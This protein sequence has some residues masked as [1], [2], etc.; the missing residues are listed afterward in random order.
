MQRRRKPVRPARP[1]RHLM[2]GCA[3][4]LLLAAGV[5]VQ[6]FQLDI[7][8]PDLA[9]R[10][11]NTLRG[12]LGM[13]LQ[14]RSGS[15]DN[16]FGFPYDQSNARFD[17]GDF[18]TKRIDWLSE[19]DV[20]YQ[21]R[22][23][24]RLSGAGWYDDAYGR[25]AAHTANPSAYVNDEYTSVVR[26]YYHGPS[27]E[28][29]DAY[30][31]GRLDA[32]TV[33]VD[34]RVGRQAVIWGEG[35]F[36]STN[37]VSYSQVPNDGR[38]AAAN[39]GASAKETAL[40]MQQVSAV[41]QITDEMT[42]AGTYS[43]QWN[44]NRLPEGGTYFAAADTILE[45]PN[46]ASREGAVQGRGG[47]VGVSLRW[48]PS[49]L[50][51]GTL[52]FYYRN[53][54]E[55]NSWANQVNAATGRRRAVY[56]KDV[57]LYGLSLTKVVAGVSVG[58]ELSY[59]RKM[60]LN[61]AGAVGVDSYGA[62]GDTVHALLNGVMT[63]GQSAAYSSASL[64]AEVGMS[65]L[66]RVTENASVFKVRGGAGC[67]V[68]PTL[69]GCS[70]RNFYTAGLSFTP[71][72]TQALPSVDLSLPLFVSY[73]FK[74][75]SAVNSGGFEGFKTLKV[76]LSANVAARHQIDLSATFYQ[77]K[78]GVVAGRQLVL[79]APYND[80]GNLTLTYQTTF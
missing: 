58:T 38:K 50:D 3:T 64:A 13:R 17:R 52:G 37:A 76:T 63:F 65:H 26:R 12:N 32:G 42:L 29:L 34:L 23:G 78:T 20:R 45:G 31:F 18:I 79:G 25:Y 19:L 72:W 80:K 71:T 33:P 16:A 27:G 28:L 70:D 11:D 75:N 48:R 9:V 59:R 55:K 54:D 69:S 30:V 56:A 60:P 57:E 7:D 21:G 74:G 41:A 51:Q 40:P 62:R 53:F 68:E 77:S 39:P 47:D 24:L 15:I 61:S 44:P 4:T 6:A 49:W 2:A 1:R 35:L 46:N 22:Y 66:V 14:H 10:W 36:G 5:P 73:N 67:T 8:N 43:L